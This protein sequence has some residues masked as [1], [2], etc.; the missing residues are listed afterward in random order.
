[1]VGLGLSVNKR[2]SPIQDDD[3]AGSKHGQ[4]NL[5]DIGAK[6]H[7]IDRPLDEPCRIEGSFGRPRSLAVAADLGGDF[8]I[9][10]LVA[11]L[12]GRA[13]SFSP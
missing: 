11:E 13:C 3:I 2:L 8:T 1:M 5:L 12:A 9:R 4:K 7:A 10:G 6:A